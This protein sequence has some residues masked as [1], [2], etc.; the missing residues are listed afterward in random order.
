M[1][2]LRKTDTFSPSAAVKKTKLFT[3]S[4]AARRDLLVPS[5]HKVRVLGME[6]WFQQSAGSRDIC[7]P[8]RIPSHLRSPRRCPVFVPSVPLP[9]QTSFFFFLKETK[10]NRCNKVSEPQ[11]AFFFLMPVPEFEIQISLVELEVK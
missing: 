1:G 8:W 9:N 5:G 7:P 11:L 4:P 6:A 3:V 2:F 10:I